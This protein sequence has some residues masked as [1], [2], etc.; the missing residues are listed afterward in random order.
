M[1]SF[2]EAPKTET[3]KVISCKSVAIS[4]EAYDEICNI[5]DRSGMKMKDVADMLIKY[6]LE[7]VTWEK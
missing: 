3:P 7:H 1:I 2:R 6:A 5:A 4:P